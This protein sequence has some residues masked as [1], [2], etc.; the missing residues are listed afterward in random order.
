MPVQLPPDLR[1][2]DLERSE[3]AVDCCFLT[4]KVTHP[5]KHGNGEWPQTRLHTHRLA[6]PSD[7]VRSREVLTIADQIG[8]PGSSFVPHATQ[9]RVDQIASRHEATPVIDSREWKGDSS[10]KNLEQLEEVPSDT[11]PI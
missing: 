9:Q 8:L 1:R 11:R 3:Q 5:T 10:L 2:I 7:Q 4:Y 6:E